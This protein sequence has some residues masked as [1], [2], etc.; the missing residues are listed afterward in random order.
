V[1]QQVASELP[2]EGTEKRT[3]E[4]RRKR[5]ADD[6]VRHSASQTPMIDKA[7]GYVF[8]GWGRKRAESRAVKRSYDALD[9]G[10]DR[11]T[12]RKADPGPI[13]DNRAS[14]SRL[15]DDARDMDKNNSFAHGV[16]NAIVDNVVGG[17]IRLEARVKTSSGRLLTPMNEEMESLWEE[18]SRGVDPGGNLQLWQMLRLAE[19]ELWVAG[20]VIIV[21]SEA[22]DRRRVPLALEIMESER[23]AALDTGD[24]GSNNLTDVG[25]GNKV[26]QG[27]EFTPSGSI[28]AYHIFDQHPNDALNVAQTQRIPASRV[29]H[30]FHPRRP[31]EIRGTTRFAP[32]TKAFQGLSQY[33]DSELTKARVASMFSVMVTRGR[34]RQGFALPSTGDAT[35]ALDA[36]GNTMGYVAP[37][38]ILTGNVGDDI[39]VAGPSISGTAFDPFVTLILRMI[40]AGLNVSYEIMTRDFSKHNF[41]SIR[42]SFL[43][44][45]RHW[46]PRQTYLVQTFLWRAWNAF[47]SAAFLQGI[48]PFASMPFEQTRQVAWITSGWDWIDP[49]KE[50][51]ADAL[52]IKVGLEN[53]KKLAARHGEDIQQNIEDLAEVKRHYEEKELDLPEEIFGGSGNAAETEIPDAKEAGGEEKPAGDDAAAE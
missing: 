35:D 21:Y 11:P 23:L 39:K 29:A 31:G 4:K 16:V 48:E 33:L 42:Q 13:S 12:P 1:S 43:E 44:D 6:Y 36:A 10:R 51:Q 50:K 7:I 41:S 9:F 47:A 14:R 26:I 37:G 49:L 8:P 45:R 18:W 5:A 20:E 40:A 24:F 27:V 3:A 38:M 19:R 30:L 15:L 28:A 22:T 32:V 52:G 34:G 17:G 46:E 2:R 25:Q 53:V